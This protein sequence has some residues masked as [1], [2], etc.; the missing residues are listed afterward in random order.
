[1][2]T[3]KTIKEYSFNP[4]D[5]KPSQLKKVWV[6]ILQFAL[7]VLLL[8]GDLIPT[9]ARPWVVLAVGVAG[10]YGVFAVSNKGASTST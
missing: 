2:T 8:A 9:D 10:A 6:N 3:E 1:M 4:F 5:Y 7:T